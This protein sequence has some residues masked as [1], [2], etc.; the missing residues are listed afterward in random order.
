MSEELGQGWVENPEAV[1]AV[2][3]SLPFP[4]FGST[5]AAGLSFEEIPDELLG[6]R[7][8]HARLKQARR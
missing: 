7:V 2:L 1:D 6:W 8:W 3:E 5:P 4:S